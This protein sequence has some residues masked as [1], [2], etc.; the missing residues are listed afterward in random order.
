MGSIQK[1]KEELKILTEQYE[2][3]MEDN[4]EEVKIELGGYLQ[5][6]L[7]VAGAGFAIWALGTGLSSILGG[8]KTKKG[9]FGKALSGFISPMAARILVEAIKPEKG[10]IEKI[11]KDDESAREDK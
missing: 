4:L 7:L 9:R 5:N 6:A 2:A 10:L 1:R 3:Q 8:K 11:E